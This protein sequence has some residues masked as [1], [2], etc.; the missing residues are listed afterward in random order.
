MYE[1][2]S[3][4]NSLRYDSDVSMPSSPEADPSRPRRNRV[5]SES[6]AKKARTKRRNLQEIMNEN[7]GSV[8]PW[9]EILFYVPEWLPPVIRQHILRRIEVSYLGAQLS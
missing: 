2:E 5:S 7:P 3:E 6:V 9:D 1:G 4:I 8:F